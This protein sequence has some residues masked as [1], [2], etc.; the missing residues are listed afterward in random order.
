MAARDGNTDCTTGINATRGMYSSKPLPYAVWSD[1]ACGGVSIPDLPMT[2]LP[3][4]CMVK[5]FVDGLSP[6]YAHQQKN[7]GD[8]FHL[9][10][11]SEEDIDKGFAFI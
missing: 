2:A 8:G 4:N 5:H 11:L 10:D 7:S 1:Q 9:G 6:V 3:D